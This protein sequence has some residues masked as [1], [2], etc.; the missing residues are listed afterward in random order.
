V[1]PCGLSSKNIMA[2]IHKNLP[3]KTLAFTE[4]G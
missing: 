2:Q 1:V 4:I 3:Y